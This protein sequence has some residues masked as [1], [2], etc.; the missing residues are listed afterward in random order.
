MG[1]GTHRCD[2]FSMD[3]AR[4]AACIGAGMVLRYLLTFLLL[5]H[6]IA[7][8]VGFVV[9]W[10]LL[11]SAEV[12][13]RTTI[14]RGAFDLGEAGIRVYGLAWLM[15]ALGFLVVGAGVLMRSGWW[16]VAMEGLVLVS[17]VFCVLDWP[18]TRRGVFANLLL[19]LVSFAAVRWSGTEMAMRNPLLDQ[20]W[21]GVK[22]GAGDKAVRL[23]MHGEI[24]L[25]R[26]Y[27][28][29]GEEVILND[30]SFV[31]AATVSMW[32]LPVCGSD[33]LVNGAG[34]MDWKLL[35][36]IPVAEAAGAD[37]TRSAKGRGVGE[38]VTFLPGAGAER[39]GSIE[40]LLDRDVGGALRSV[41]FRRWGNPGGGAFAENE[42]GVAVDEERVLGGHK[43]PVK[44]RAG[45]FF[46]TE[47]FEREGEFFRATIIEAEYR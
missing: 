32:G 15:L 17:L 23:K 19:L 21:A 45:W 24:K 20:L 38:M 3:S 6:G 31:W 10:R 41:R 22:S 44:I 11:T 9:P 5:A 14:L 30:G 29:T 46:G 36:V 28:F 39:V 7:H 43:I 26:W 18:M 12:P 42:F 37:V 8:L 35:G 4:P 33:R 27:P 16:L 2:V 1:E 40:V 25:G 13:Y 47:R 34:A